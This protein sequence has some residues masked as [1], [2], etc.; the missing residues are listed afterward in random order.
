MLRVILYCLILFVIEM[1]AVMA[2]A[3]KKT[4]GE[5]ILIE[6]SLALEWAGSA[7]K[8]YELA[9]RFFD[10]TFVDSGAARMSY[11]IFIPTDQAV[12]V[13]RDR[14]TSG[15]VS[16]FEGR[17]DAFWLLLLRATQRM[18][19]Y[20][21]WFIWALLLL[22][23]AAYDGWCQRA[24][25]RMCFG[26]SSAVRYNLA[27]YTTIVLCF[28][29]VYAM[30]LPVVIPPQTALLWTACAMLALRMLTANIQKMI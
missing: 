3:D 16:W 12:P 5:E 25:K 27:I 11:E 9:Q 10:R 4:V 30:F 29:P 1:V 2:L 19:L 14:Y 26:Y 28:A 7:Q 13:N 20:A 8:T 17:L 24:I 22:F 18:T 6:H 23:P 15:T 21:S